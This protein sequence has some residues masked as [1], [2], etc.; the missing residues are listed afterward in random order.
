MADRK[1]R[2]ADA[3]Q[4]QQFNE[5]AQDLVREIGVNDMQGRVQ[6]RLKQIF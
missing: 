3:E 5:G 2:L 6:G 4:Q 1:R